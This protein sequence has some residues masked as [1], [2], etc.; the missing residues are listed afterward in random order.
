MNID[1]SHRDS[2]T[3]RPDLLAALLRRRAVERADEQYRQ[4][5][6]ETH[7]GINGQ[8]ITPPHLQRA[9]ATARRNGAGGLFR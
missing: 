2:R 6:A 7:A 9:Q 5:H 8:P 3:P 1:P 4:D